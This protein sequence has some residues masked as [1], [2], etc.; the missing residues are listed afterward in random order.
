[1]SEV[2]MN[3]LKAIIIF[4]THEEKFGNYL[5]IYKIIWSDQ[6]LVVKRVDGYLRADALA[7][8]FEPSWDKFGKFMSS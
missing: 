5:Q 3:S 2:P 1:M 6:K 4:D 7:R 8:L